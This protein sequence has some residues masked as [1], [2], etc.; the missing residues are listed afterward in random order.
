MLTFPVLG[1]RE[2]EAGTVNVR[3]RDNKVLGE[4]TVEQL[5][6]RL[7]VLTESKLLS[8]EDPFE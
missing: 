2:K 3:T 1:E 5:L 4:R 6:K 8:S 7:K